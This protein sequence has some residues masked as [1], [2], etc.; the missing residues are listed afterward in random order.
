MASVNKVQIIG[1]I[2]RD[3]EFK[4]TS[5]GTPVCRLSV[6]TNRKWTNKNGE[7]EEESEFHR[8][9]VW[10]KQ[11]EHCNNYLSKG[12]SVYVEGRLKTSS[13]ESDGVKKYS[14]EIIAENVQ[15]LGGR[16]SSSAAPARVERQET[17]RTEPEP[18][19]PREF[20]GGQDG[21]PF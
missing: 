4:H 20:G 16:P 21:I 12:R 8:V 3:P 6:A 13:Y 17:R 19:D 1:N 14:T 11:A 15:F 7:R 9:T 10:G 18:Y 2:T 5:A